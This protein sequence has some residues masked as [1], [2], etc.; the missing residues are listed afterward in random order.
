MAIRPLATGPSTPDSPPS[1][2]DR[3]PNAPAAL[4]TLS[5]TLPSMGL[6]VTLGNSSSK[7]FIL[8]FANGFTNSVSITSAALEAEFPRS[9]YA[10]AASR[11]SS[12]S[13]GLS[14]DLP[15]VPPGSIRV[16]PPLSAAWNS[17]YAD[18]ASRMLSATRLNTAIAPPTAPSP[19]SPAIPPPLPISAL[20]ALCAAVA[21][22]SAYAIRSYMETAPGFTSPRS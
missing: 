5:A 8:K 20:N 1:T 14:P 3:L 17:L 12:A 4:F 18:V 13:N 10:R 2:L 21:S 19:N 9:S 16:A 11:I 7:G 22:L 15:P 6:S